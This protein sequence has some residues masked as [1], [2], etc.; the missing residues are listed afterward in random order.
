MEPNEVNN[1]GKEEPVIDIKPAEK[2]EIKK[3]ETVDEITDFLAS[4]SIKIFSFEQMILTN[5]IKIREQSEEIIKNKFFIEKINLDAKTFVYSPEQAK[6][7][8]NES[9]RST[10]IKNLVE[11]NEEYKKFVQINLE[12]DK[13]VKQ[14]ET[15]NDKININLRYFQRLYEIYI[16]LL[17]TKS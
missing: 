1:E 16:T 14:I 3:P 10:A 8:T 12:A 17:K 9:S 13:V 11:A 5:K 6:I 2:K 15:D 7:Y 4:V